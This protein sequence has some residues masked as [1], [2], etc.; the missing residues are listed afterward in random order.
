MKY[1][2]L[3]AVLILLLAL[4]ILAQILIA[5]R[6][7]PED[8]MNSSTKPLEFGAGDKSL[9]YAVMGDSTAAGQGADY[10]QGIA[11]RSAKHLAKNQ[12]VTMVNFGRSGA[13]T[14]DVLQ[15]QLPEAVKVQPDLVLVSTGAN[16]VTTLARPRKAKRDLRKIVDKLIEANCSVKIVITGAPDMG[17]IPRFAQPLRFV[18]GL[19]TIRYNRIVLPLADEK[20]ITL[21]PIAAETGQT[22]RENP[23]LFAND[24]FHPNEEGYALWAKTINPALDEAVSS[25]PSHC[26]Y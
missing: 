23:D 26:S 18:A 5:R 20:N 8:F 24:K 16:D 17:S 14:A 21:A 22:F 4:I 3:A 1:L 19:A 6:N 25:Q 11:A 10:D 13:K 15:N 2:G 12:P 9:R 7:P